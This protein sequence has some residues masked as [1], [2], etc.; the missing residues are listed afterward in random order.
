MGLSAILEKKLH[1]IR[2]VIAQGLKAK[3]SA[4]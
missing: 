1:G 2:Q 4:I 3:L